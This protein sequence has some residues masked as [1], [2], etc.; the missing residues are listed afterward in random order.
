MKRTIVAGAA[1]L[2]LAAAATAATNQTASAT[3][4]MQLKPDRVSPTITVDAKDG[5]RETRTHS[6]WRGGTETKVVTTF[7][8]GKKADGTVDAFNWKTGKSQFWCT[9]VGT[10]GYNSQ[11]VA[12]KVTHRS[13]KNIYMQIRAGRNNPYFRNSTSK[14]VMIEHV[15]LHTV[16]PDRL[17]IDAYRTTGFQPH[18]WI[19]AATKLDTEDPVDGTLG[20]NTTTDGH[21]WGP[22]KTYAGH[23]LSDWPTK[24]F[25]QG[26]YRTTVNIQ[27]IP[28]ALFQMHAVS[29]KGKVS[30]E[31]SNCGGMVGS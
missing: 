14:R 29:D 2:A 30:P 6:E 21:I 27:A 23:Q 8:A 26:G 15:V 18:P 31:Y 25:T 1:V 4:Q 17:Y 16:D 19:P 20:L 9:V 11:I 5:S 22:G 13:G 3:G 24:T 12:F 7:Y 28:D 10:G